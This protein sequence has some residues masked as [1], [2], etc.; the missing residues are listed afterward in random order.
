[1]SSIMEISASVRPPYSAY[2]A[3][4]ARRAAWRIRPIFLGQLFEERVDRQQ[5]VGRALCSRPRRQ[6]DPDGIR[7]LVRPTLP[8]VVDQ[9]RR[10]CVT[11][12]ATTLGSTAPRPP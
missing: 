8:G 9:L 6:G 3:T 4:S 1:M 5:R 2:R 7:S 11:A 12:K 10:M